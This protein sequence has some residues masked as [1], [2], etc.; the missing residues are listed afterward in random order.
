[1]SAV[2]VAAA[3]GP[4]IAGMGHTS[5]EQINRSPQNSS[6]IGRFSDRAR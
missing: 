2:K 5:A 1:M 3:L 4:A 6:F